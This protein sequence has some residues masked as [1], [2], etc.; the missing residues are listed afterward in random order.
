[1][2]INKPCSFNSQLESLKDGML[3]YW[4]ILQRTEKFIIPETILF[5]TAST[6]SDVLKTWG[7]TKRHYSLFSGLQKILTKFPFMLKKA[8]S[9]GNYAVLTIIP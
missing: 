9:C 7:L 4:V 1:M 2:L 3:E 8:A 5:L 6:L